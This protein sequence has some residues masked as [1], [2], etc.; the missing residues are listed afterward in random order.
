MNE[1]QL[2]MATSCRARVST[3]A[4]APM[5]QRHVG[6]FSEFSPVRVPPLGRAKIGQN[7]DEIEKYSHGH[8]ANKRAFVCAATL[9]LINVEE[10][11]PELNLSDKSAL[12]YL[13][14]VCED[15]GLQG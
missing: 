15:S 9:L 3:S 1:E 14:Y 5:D 10:I 4:C 2:K 13:V 7:W 6:Y 11:M 8:D 12:Q